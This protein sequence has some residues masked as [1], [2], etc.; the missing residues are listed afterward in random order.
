MLNGYF[1][2]GGEL[3]WGSGGVG[4]GWIHNCVCSTCILGMVIF[5][6]AKMMGVDGGRR[7]SVVGVFFV[8]KQSCGG[9]VV[10]GGGA[11]G[12]V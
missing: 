6:G 12:K 8:G 10:L 11:V 2:G 1:L 5:V 9:G 7:G 4:A 3:C